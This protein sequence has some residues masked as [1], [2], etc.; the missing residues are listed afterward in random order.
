MVDENIKAPDK[1]AE[2]EKIE[3]E[4][5]QFTKEELSKLIGLGKIGKEAENK[6]NTKLDRVYP[7]YT[8]SRQELAALKKDY[9][10]L[11]KTTQN[12]LK[13]EGEP[14]S[15]E[16]IT[17]QAIAEADR[18][19]LIHKGNIRQYYFEMR[20]AERLLEDAE[21]VSAQAKTEGLP[22]IKVDDL[23]KHMEETGIKNPQ[24]AYNDMFE[25]QID[26]IKEQKILS[27]KKQTPYTEGKSGEGGIEPK[28][29][30]PTRENLT[31]LLNEHF[32]NAQ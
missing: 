12:P 20:Q 7:E 32:R 28:K 14:L 22:E 25:K 1:G 26:K 10:E 5:E 19:G 15:Q 31:Q 16:E 29:I 24:K 13:A 30:I 6:F 23:L 18:L 11:K 2:P 4:G 17:K 8:K 9:E 27:L 21:E 3:I